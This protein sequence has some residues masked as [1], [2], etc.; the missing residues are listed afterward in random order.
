MEKIHD[1]AR[2]ARA[3]KHSFGI[4]PEVKLRAYS[5]ECHKDRG[6]DAIREE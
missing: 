4:P 5:L 3:E 6:A 2:L 1:G